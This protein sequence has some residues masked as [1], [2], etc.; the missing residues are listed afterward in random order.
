MKAKLFAIAILLIAV[1]SSTAIPVEKTDVEYSVHDTWLVQGDNIYSHLV[2]DRYSQNQDSDAVQ[3]EQLNF[4]GSINPADDWQAL[5]IPGKEFNGVLGYRLND[6]EILWFNALIIYQ[7]EDDYH[8]YILGI[9]V[10]SL[11]TESYFV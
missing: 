6:N 8:F 9:F 11:N 10:Q 3:N 7:D 5:G 4:E 1:V 2:F